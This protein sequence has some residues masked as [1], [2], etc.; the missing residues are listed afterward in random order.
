MQL[1]NRAGFDVNIAPATT[2]SAVSACKGPTA[3]NKW[4]V[5]MS[6]TPSS[7]ITAG[8]GDANCVLNIGAAGLDW[9]RI[10]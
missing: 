5:R 10:E 8:F 2:L 7:A 3:L 6:P 4:I 9:A 1:I